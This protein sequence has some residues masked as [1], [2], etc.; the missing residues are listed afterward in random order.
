MSHT[1]HVATG[2]YG[3]MAEF[4]SAAALLKAAE[5]ARDAG[6]TKTDAYSPMPIHG[7]D[8]AIGFKEHLLPKFVF[9][10]GLTGA[11]FGYGF[12]Y[13]TQGIAYPLNIGG[14]AYYSWVS[15]IPPAYELT[16]LFA[17]L[18]AFG[19]M[20]VLNG[21]PRHYHPV[22]N[23]PNFAR[24]SQD[25]FFLTIEAADPK[26]HIDETRAFLAQLNAREVVA[27]DE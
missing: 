24:A 11:L 23:N 18:T 17:A 7:M 21:L 27:F 3:L 1:A 19:S 26:F 6:Y 8:E 10:A 14:R 2:P 12:E 5:R 25:R 16:I 13:W 4:D 9:C 20:L 22:F 15:F